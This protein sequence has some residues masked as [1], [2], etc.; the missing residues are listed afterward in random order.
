MQV[1]MACEA[2]SG[3]H[4]SCCASSSQAGQ[5]PAADF[6]SLQL[7]GA[8]IPCIVNALQPACDCLLSQH[9]PGLVQHVSHSLAP[10]TAPCWLGHLSAMIAF[11]AVATSTPSYWLAAAALWHVG[12]LVG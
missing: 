8:V 9:L 11:A 1:A 4:V 5:Q 7:A 12:L 6:G 3:T 2:D 10:A